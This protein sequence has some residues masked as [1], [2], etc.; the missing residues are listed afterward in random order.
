MKALGTKK[1]SK[2][3]A[4][5][6]AWYKSSRNKSTGIFTAVRIHAMTIIAMG[7]IVR[8]YF[9][10]S[11]CF[12]K[13]NNKTLNPI[14]YADIT[15]NPKIISL[16]ATPNISARNGIGRGA[17]PKFTMSKS[18]SFPPPSIINMINKAIFVCLPT[19]PGSNF[20][21]CSKNLIASRNI[22]LKIDNHKLAVIQS[23]LFPKFNN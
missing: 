6:P 2:I 20:L 3:Q 8:R 16:G 7:I 15:T 21:A 22:T 12:S 14:I 18:K 9:V 10:L 13:T 5:D 23:M 4:S 17:D 11:V 19:D 1:K